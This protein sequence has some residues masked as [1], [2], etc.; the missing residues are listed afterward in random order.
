MADDINALFLAITHEG[1]L[2][3]AAYQSLLLQ[4]FAWQRQYILR[5]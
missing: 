4:C 2:L 1:A 3:L 5:N